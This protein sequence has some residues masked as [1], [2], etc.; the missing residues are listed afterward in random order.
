[1]S[2]HLALPREG[3]LAQL[4]HMFAH[5]N[6]EIMLDLSDPVINQSDFALQDCTSSEF[7]GK[8]FPPTC[9]SHED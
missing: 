2:L 7:G 3:H 8:R 5:H 6:A 9:L 1:M 4:F